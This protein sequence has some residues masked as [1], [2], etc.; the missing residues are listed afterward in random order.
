M[1]TFST[2][3]DQGARQAREPGNAPPSPLDTSAE[4]PSQS[5]MRVRPAVCQSAQSDQSSPVYRSPNKLFRNSGCPAWVLLVPSLANRSASADLSC[6][7]TSDDST[8]LPLDSVPP[9]QICFCRCGTLRR[10]QRRCDSTDRTGAN[11]PAGRWQSI[12]RDKSFRTPFKS[13][14]AMEV[15]SDHCRCCLTLTGA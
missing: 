13:L 10:L 14:E 6:S 11:R 1:G 7:T 5:R 12:Y 3:T 9:C 8:G 4:H 2:L 15:C